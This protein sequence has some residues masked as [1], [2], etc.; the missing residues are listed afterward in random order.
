M[1]PE[2]G[3]SDSSELAGPTNGPRRSGLSRWGPTFLLLGVMA[4]YLVATRSAPALEGWGTDFD[5]ALAQAAASDRRVLVAFNMR[6]CPPCTMMDRMVL[7]K[8][9]VR[10]ALEG[11]VPVRVDVDQQRL[12]ASR[13]QVFSTP[14][15]AVIDRAGNLVARSEGYQSTN[16]FVKFLERGLTQPAHRL[17]RGVLLRP[18]GLQETGR[19]GSP[20][21]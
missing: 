21:N 4:L 6:G 16:T 12:L 7:G 1:I 18:S 8:R 3:Q 2:T 5:T 17:D 10:S 15:Y 14:T 19:Y 11:Y 20:D 13:F 9:A